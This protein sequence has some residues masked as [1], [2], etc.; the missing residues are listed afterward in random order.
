[1]LHCRQN[2]VGFFEIFFFLIIIALFI[3]QESKYT[4][5]NPL[6]NFPSATLNKLVYLKKIS[7]VI[8]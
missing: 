8:S 6:G 1:M 7:T 3:C 4:I 5:K 2:K